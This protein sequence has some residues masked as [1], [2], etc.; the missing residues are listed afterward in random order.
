MKCLSRARLR[1]GGLVSLM[2]IQIEVLVLSLLLCRLITRRSY[3]VLL[4]HLISG[5]R[6]GSAE[7]RMSHL[8]IKMSL[9]LVRVVRNCN[10]SVVHAHIFA[11]IS[12]DKID[13]GWKVSTTSSSLWRIRILGTGTVYFPGVLPF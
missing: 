9:E 11:H 6:G 5:L 4:S 3:G 2:A 7:F 12:V 1:A 10:W 8:S 13:L